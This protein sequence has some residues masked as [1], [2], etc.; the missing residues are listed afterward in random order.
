MVY[1]RYIETNYLPGDLLFCKYVPIWTTDFSIH[2][3]EERGG[4]ILLIWREKWLFVHPETYA[5]T[6]NC[7]LPRT[8]GTCVCWW[9]GEQSLW[10]Y[11]TWQNIFRNHCEPLSVHTHTHTH[12]HPCKHRSKPNVPLNQP[13]HMC[14]CCQHLRHVSYDT[15][16]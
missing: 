14:V 9:E 8:L 11:Q 15:N 5:I 12:T 10:H 4:F 13:L 6:K 16:S 1:V 7:N 2:H 3:F